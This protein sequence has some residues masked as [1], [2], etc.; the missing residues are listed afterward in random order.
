MCLLHL[1][2][3]F[4]IRYGVKNYLNVSGAKRLD[5]ELQTGE[6]GVVWLEVRGFRGSTSEH[7]PHASFRNCSTVSAST[8]SENIS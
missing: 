4:G 6:G 1:I 2:K 3:I 8:A 5:V 7:P